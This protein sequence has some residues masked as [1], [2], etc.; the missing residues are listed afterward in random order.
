MLAGAA[1]ADTVEPAR[2]EPA[3]L[4]ARMAG[5]MMVRLIGMIPPWCLQRSAGP[6]HDFGGTRGTSELPGVI[7][8][9]RLLHDLA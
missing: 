4:S 9:F 6:L 3:R 8:A 1:T 7:A 2:I 5:T